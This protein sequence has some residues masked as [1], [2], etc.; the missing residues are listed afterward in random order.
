M[1]VHSA[2]AICPGVAVLSRMVDQLTNT[3]IQRAMPIAHKNTEWFGFVTVG[4]K[5]LRFN[6]LQ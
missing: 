5:I 3:A 2:V 4:Q 6:W 1:Y